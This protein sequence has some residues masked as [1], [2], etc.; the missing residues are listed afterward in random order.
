MMN[1]K[2]SPFLKLALVVGLLCLY[3]PVFILVI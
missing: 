2:I 3:I 1:N